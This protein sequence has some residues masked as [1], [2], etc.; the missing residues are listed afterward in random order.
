MAGLDWQLLQL[1]L[2]PDPGPGSEL[3]LLP[4]PFLFL[5]PCCLPLPPCLPP[6]LISTVSASLPLTLQLWLQHCSNPTPAQGTY[7]VALAI[8]QPS[9]SCGSSSDLSAALGSGQSCYCHK[10]LCALVWGQSNDVLHVLQWNGARVALESEPELELKP[11][12]KWWGRKRLQ[13]AEVGGEQAA[14]GD[15]VWGQVLRGTGIGEASSRVAGARGMGIRN[16]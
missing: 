4:I 1:Q 16:G 5:L 3:Q 7:M 11:E 14:G 9:S 13:R 10:F 6:C 12:G 2:L 8:A 15:Q